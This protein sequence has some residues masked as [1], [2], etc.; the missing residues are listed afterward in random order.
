ME[1]NGDFEFK[2]NRMGKNSGIVCF[3]VY[4]G[5]RREKTVVLFD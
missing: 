4:L 2:R 3:V 5:G 1:F